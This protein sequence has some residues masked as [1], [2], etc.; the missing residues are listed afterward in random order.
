MTRPVLILSMLF[1]VILNTSTFAHA[2]SEI[3]AS[4][5]WSH[6]QLPELTVLRHDGSEGPVLEVNVNWREIHILSGSTLKCPSILV[7]TTRQVFHRPRCCL[8]WTCPK[9][10]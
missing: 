1:L 9:V 3:V 6:A 4:L 8:P 5:D 7:A 10:A 2:E